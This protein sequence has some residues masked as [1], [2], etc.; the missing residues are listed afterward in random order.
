ML[1]CRCWVCAAAA[2]SAFPVPPGPGRSRLGLVREVPGCEPQREGQS[3]RAEETAR[4]AGAALGAML[5]PPPP[6]L[7][8]SDLWPSPASRSRVPER[9][10]A[11]ETE[12]E[13]NKEAALWE[14]SRLPAPR[15]GPALP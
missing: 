3:A 8:P 10:G 13:L 15:R 12:T 2:G 9:A 7:R 14:P 4:R 11:S 1:S 6:G 5:P